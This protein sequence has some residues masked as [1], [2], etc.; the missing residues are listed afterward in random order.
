MTDHDFWL[1]TRKALLDQVDAIERKLG[2]SPTTAE[3]RRANKKKTYLHDEIKK[4]IVY[5]ERP[6]A[7][8]S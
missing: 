6:L 1:A 3:L 4:D 5:S 7:T 2:I 8:R